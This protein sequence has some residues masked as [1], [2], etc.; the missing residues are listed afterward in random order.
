MKEYA[1]WNIEQAVIINIVI[2][3]TISR[4]TYSQ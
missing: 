3:H 4:Q 2:N 1:K